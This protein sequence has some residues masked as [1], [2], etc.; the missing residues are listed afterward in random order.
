MI[1][2]SALGSC[3]DMVRQVAAATTHLYIRENFRPERLDF[4][5]QQW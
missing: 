4:F 3:F 5:F 1:H 2:A